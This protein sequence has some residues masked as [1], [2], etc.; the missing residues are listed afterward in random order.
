MKFENIFT[1]NNQ[2][3]DIFDWFNSD[4]NAVDCFLA[5]KTTLFEYHIGTKSFEMVTV[6]I[7]TNTFSRIRQQLNCSKH[8]LLPRHQSNIISPCVKHYNTAM[9]AVM[10]KLNLKEPTCFNYFLVLHNE[11]AENGII[12]E[13]AE[14]ILINSTY[15]IVVG[16]YDN[17]PFMQ[18][19][20]SCASSSN[21]KRIISCGDPL[22]WN[23]NYIGKNTKILYRK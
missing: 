10:R 7:G 9:R 15:L 5:L 19:I 16:N 17:D 20:T 6:F 18:A 13:L 12:S 11:K 14:D 4:T 23:H 2:P 8:S 1:Y 22:E 3:N 21:I